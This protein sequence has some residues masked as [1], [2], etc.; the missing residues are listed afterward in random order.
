VVL[1]ALASAVLI[2]M[3]GLA[4]DVG[5]AYVER[6]YLQNATDAG[7]LAAGSSYENFGNQ[8]TAFDAALT[9]FERNL[10]LGAPDSTSSTASSRTATWGTYSFTITGANGQFNGYVFQGTASHPIPL[11]VMQVIGAGNS[12][13]VQAQ[14]SA[15]VGAQYSNPALLTLDQSVSSLSLSGSASVTVRGDVYSDGGIGLS[16]TSSLAIAGS[17]YS[18]VGAPPS[19]I[20]YWCYNPNPGI[21][22]HAPA[23]SSGETQG[24]A[25][26]S[27]P[28]LPDP[29]YPGGNTS[30]YPAVDPAPVG[31]PTHLGWTE[32]KPGIYHN[33]SLT[34][35]ASCYFF[36]P[37]IYQWSGGY[38]SHG[39]FSSNELKAPDEPA[40]NYTTSSLDYTSRANP[41]FWDPKNCSGVFTV[42]GAVAAVGLGLPV[43]ATWS[44]EM[45]SVRVDAYP[46][47]G[48]AGTQS[49]ARESAPSMCHSVSLAGTNNAIAVTLTSHVPG[50]QYYNIYMAPGACAGLAQTAY[51]FVAQIPDLPGSVTLN[52][53]NVPAGTGWIRGVR[54]SN[55]NLNNT[56]GTVAMGCAPPDGEQPAYCFVSCSGTGNNGLFQENAA[57]AQ[58]PQGDL[59]NENYC[60]PW[61]SN[62]NGAKVTPGAVQFYFPANGDCLNENGNGQSFVFS[63]YQYQWI[64]IYQT[65]ANTSC[66]N[67]LN[68]GTY[69]SYIGTVYTPASTWSIQ[70]GS[71]APLAGQVIAYDASLSGNSVI[72]INFDPRYAPA[73]PAA[74]LVQ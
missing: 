46:P 5:R 39:G 25:N 9:A 20:T 55:C 29:N 48:F 66:G 67:V 19:A 49:Y 27:A 52:S 34:G 38:S 63:G 64:G 69:T 43:P 8:T 35:G 28:L 3:L 56:N 18:H 10:T 41:Q 71:R 61:A 32:L 22:P 62:C 6:R 45:T 17:A 7:T 72:G 60:L 74:R 30:Y 59:A 31:A 58:P 2:G 1:I 54:D 33:W 21:A 4:V 44:I 37:G 57:R 36:D 47:T 53:S 12:A 70:G 14:A 51:G 65:H 23:C 11:T 42:A 16:G 24:A 50:A 40:W 15:I 13:T 73:P 68:G 26:P